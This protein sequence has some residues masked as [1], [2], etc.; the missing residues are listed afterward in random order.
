VFL[1]SPNPDDGALDLLLLKGAANKRL[2][3][4]LYN[5]IGGH[6]EADED[7]YAAAQ[8]EV[9]EETGLRVNHL[10]LRAIVNIDTGRDEQGRRPG[11][12][13]FVFWGETNARTVSATAEGAPEWVAL[14]RVYDLPLVDD[15]YALLPHV[16][17]GAFV[18]GHYAPAGDGT[19]TYRYKRV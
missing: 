9:W 5:G 7:I 13:M 10:S 16:L 4:G 15:L 11:V 8:R 19:L 17:S 3:A 18:Y 6:V 12:L 14:A 1:S 2:W